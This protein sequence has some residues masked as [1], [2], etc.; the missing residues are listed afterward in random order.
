[1]LSMNTM[2]EQSQI[3][4][5]AA[6]RLRRNEFQ[7][8]LGWFI[9]NSDHG[10]LKNFL[11]GEQRIGADGQIVRTPEGHHNAIQ[12]VAEEFEDLVFDLGLQYRDDMVE[13]PHLNEL[14][15]F[16]AFLMTLPWRTTSYTFCRPQQ[17]ALQ[18]ILKPLY[19]TSTNTPEE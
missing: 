11:F 5:I 15:E 6:D 9:A 10:W 1:M 17:Y 18:G 4:G 16:C 12:M 3:C 19:G 8:A 13:G 2:D 14:N 7:L